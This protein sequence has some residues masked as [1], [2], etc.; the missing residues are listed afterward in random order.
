MSIYVTLGI[1]V[2]LEQGGESCRPDGHQLASTRTSALCK[3][4]LQVLIMISVVSCTYKP[5]WLAGPIKIENE[6]AQRALFD[7]PL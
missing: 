4:H 5:V 2:S 6:F 1:Y 3:Q 7:L